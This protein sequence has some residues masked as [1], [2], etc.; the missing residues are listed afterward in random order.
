MFAR[1]NER[2]AASLSRSGRVLTR[3]RRRRVDL[4]R[5]GGTAC[6]RPGPGARRTRSRRRATRA[7]WRE[8]ADLE[9]GEQRPGLHRRVAQTLRAR[10]DRPRAYAGIDLATLRD[11]RLR[12]TSK[13]SPADTDPQPAPQHIGALTPP[14]TGDAI[15]IAEDCRSSAHHPHI[16]DIAKG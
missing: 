4:Q 13:A 8:S 1:C 7:Q 12:L 11:C 15:R 16:T 14:I 6:A 5:G 9:S 3:N 2:S 10:A